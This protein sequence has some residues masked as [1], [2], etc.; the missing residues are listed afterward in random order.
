M[1][2]GSTS[3]R[4]F[5][6]GS[7]PLRRWRLLAIFFVVYLGVT[8]APGF[9]HSSTVRDGMAILLL[10]LPWAVITPVLIFWIDW[11][12]EC[13]RREHIV[14]CLVTFVVLCVISEAVSKTPTTRIP[15]NDER[16]TTN[17]HQ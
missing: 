11:A 4:S 16:Q 3:F 2:D 1:A 5:M 17:D 10:N 13:H 14:L 7:V 9:A 8:S 6:A 15:A 12:I